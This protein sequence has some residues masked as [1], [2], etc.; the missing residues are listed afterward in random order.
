MTLADA[1]R[2]VRAGAE[3]DP[4]A[5][6][7]LLEMAVERWPEA[8][9]DLEF[10]RR[11]HPEIPVLALVE[12]GGRERCQE[13]RRAGASRAVP[14]PLPSGDPFWFEEAVQGAVNEHRLQADLERVNEQLLQ[15]SRFLERSSVTDPLTGLLNRRGLRQALAREMKRVSRS[16]EGLEV[17]LLDLDDFHQVNQQLGFASGDVILAEVGR[18]L[19]ETLRET[20]TL[21]RIGGDDFLI[22]LPG[23]RPAEAVRVAEKV[24]FALQSCPVVTSTRTLRLSASMGMATV[25]DSVLGIDEILALVQ[26]QLERSRKS[27]GKVVCHS[28]EDPAAVEGSDLAERTARRLLAGEGLRAVAQPIVRLGDHA[29]VGYEM[30]ARFDEEDLASPDRFFILSQEK[31]LLTSV[32]LHCFR[33]GL[34]AVPGLG[35][36]DRIHL[37]LFP[38]TILDLSAERLVDMLAGEEEVTYCIEISE[39][40]VIGDPSYLIESVRA[41]QEA[42]IE[43]AID[44]VGFGRSCLESLILLEPDIVKIDKRLVTGTADHP[45]RVRG[46]QRLLR[47]A[48]ALRCRTVAEGIESRTDLAVARNLG[49]Q[50]GQ[51]WLLGAP[52]ELDAIVPAA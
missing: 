51:G 9:L 19:R 48:E 31:E 12:G 29:L 42:G 22:L 44:D 38:S 3:V 11:E 2:P 18:R 45:A 17:L 40:Q 34:A 20:D 26:A 4:V 8:L 23:V 5:D 33:A 24:H 27:R 37:N 21:A 28:S 15:V 46:L 7:L 36:V 32:D 14:A 16:G 43:V 47:V 39:Q 10:L 30:L 25:P 13:A 49:V 35:S 50:F 6:A 41:F 52:L 1:G